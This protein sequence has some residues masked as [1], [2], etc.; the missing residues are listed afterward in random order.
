MGDDWNKPRDV[1]PT[2]KIE[3]L[4]EESPSPE[5]YRGKRKKEPVEAVTQ[6]VMGAARGRPLVITLRREDEGG[7]Y[8]VPSR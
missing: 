6:S 7:M 1:G 2:E 5:R 8:S 3:S 4:A